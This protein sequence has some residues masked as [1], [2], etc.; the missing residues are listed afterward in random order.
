M[1]RADAFLALG[2]ERAHG[3]AQLGPGRQ[4]PHPGNAQAQVLP[5]GSLDELIQDGVVEGPPPVPVIVG[6]RGYLPIALSLQPLGHRLGL[7]FHKV[8]PHLDAPCGHEE[9][10]QQNSTKFGVAHSAPPA[11][12]HFPEWL[13]RSVFFGRMDLDFV[14]CVSNA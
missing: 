2:I 10:D 3:D 11:A 6:L 5:V 9:D 4:D 13:N 8:R 12:R 7:R 14:E 1:Q